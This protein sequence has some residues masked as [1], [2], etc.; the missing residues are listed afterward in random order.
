MAVSVKRKAAI[1]RW[2]AAG[3][4]A[5][6]RKGRKRHPLSTT[7]DQTLKDSDAAFKLWRVAMTRPRRK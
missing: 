7:I 5:K 4:A 3:A 2:Q 6:K 1:K